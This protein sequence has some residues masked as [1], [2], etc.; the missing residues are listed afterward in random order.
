MIYFCSDW[1]FNHNKEFIYKARGYNSIEQMNE[2]IITNYNSLVQPN[3]ICY[4]LGDLCLG[5]ADLLQK[6]KA[7]IERLN[8]NIIVL[9]GNH[10]TNNR[11]EM[12]RTCSNIIEI[13][14][15]AT[16]L[17]YKKFNFFLSHYPTVCEN[18]SDGKS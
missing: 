5:G 1:H 6:N 7:L 13:C 16:M 8:G 17:K 15:Y 2:A 14:G 9:L 10:D 3:D 18:Y 4:V 11:M 12:Y